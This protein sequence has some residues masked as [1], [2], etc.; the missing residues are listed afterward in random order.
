MKAPE[1][2]AQ[3]M[4]RNGA[5]V[6]NLATGEVERISGREEETHFN[7]QEDAVSL[8]ETAVKETS[9]AHHQ[10]RERKAAKAD[11]KTSTATIKEIIRLMWLTPYSCQSIP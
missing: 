7:P 4:T 10:H 5:V 3:K 2:V 9:H 11:A 1:K 6:E 8:T